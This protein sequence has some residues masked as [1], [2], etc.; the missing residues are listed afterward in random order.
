ML[1]GATNNISIG[2]HV[3]HRAPRW[4]VCSIAAVVAMLLV[5]TAAFHE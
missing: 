3:D 4:L 1:S 2:Q 5:E